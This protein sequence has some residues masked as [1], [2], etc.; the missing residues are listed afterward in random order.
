MDITIGGRT[1]P[2]YFSTYEMIAIEKEI[3]CTA[4]QLRDEV[5]GLH[6]ADLDDPNSWAMDV[7]TDT[8]KTEKLG[9]LIAI[10]GNAGLEE[11]GE[12][13]DLTAKWILRKMK[14]NKIIEY[15]ILASLAIAEG[16]KSEVAEKTDEEQG[17]VDEMIEEEN[18]KKEPVK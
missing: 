2:L 10:L 1:V 13:P 4:A 12:T 5:F 7:G 18:R 17:P 6:L 8:A 15:A 9:K 14:P 11:A 3:G 16:N